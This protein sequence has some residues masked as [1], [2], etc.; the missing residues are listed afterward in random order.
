MTTTTPQA[1]VGVNVNADGK[2]YHIEVPDGSNIE[3]AIQASGL[4]LGD[5]DRVEPDL[6]SKII[7][8]LEIKIVRVKEAF[9]V[10]EV[11]VPFERRV[12]Q[13]ESLPEQET[14]LAQKGENGL[15]EITYRHLYEDGVEMT[16]QQV[17]SQKVIREAVPEIIMVGVQSPFSPIAIP[18]RLLY[19]VGG[20]AWMMEN[21]TTN[22][23]LLI[24][25]GDLDGRIFSISDNGEWLLFTRRSDEDGQINSL[26][27][28]HIT[29]GKDT[30]EPIDLEA[31]NIIHFAD[32]KPGLSSTTVLY[33][34][35]EPRTTA[36]GWQANNDLISVNVSANGWLSKKT[37]I[38]EPNSGGV[39]GWWGTTFAWQPGTNS[40]LY[41]RPD[42]IGT[43]DLENGTL[44]PLFDILPLQTRSDWAWIPPVT[45]S[46]D[47]STI[48]SVNHMPQE[49]LTSQEESPVF[50]LSA[51]FLENRMLISLFQNTGMFAYPAVS[52]VQSTSNSGDSFQVAFLQAIFPEQS[53]NSR[54]RLV[55]I[56]RD[57]SNQKTLFPPEGQPGLEPQQMVWSPAVFDEQ[58]NYAVAILYQ[59]NIWFIKTGENTSDSYQITGDGLT[60]RL[61]WV[62]AE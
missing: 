21:T 19:L 24:S 47:G 35:V 38:I 42:G 48:Y 45:W 52:P 16:K 36:P 51:L 27:A 50:N 22:R 39:Y 34:T 62:I 6:A 32:W 43:V 13:T 7:P 41:S 10:E 23:K 15:V 4:S 61:L 54:Y 18:G 14:M 5:L 30:E 12:L 55:V 28:L 56:D 46:P 60:S 33:S 53:D 2:I 20:N 17:A 37:T 58:S 57:G 26:W 44:T 59:G 49:G 31:E 29:S 8:D 25:T 9:T 11:T 40:L 1:L 3:Q